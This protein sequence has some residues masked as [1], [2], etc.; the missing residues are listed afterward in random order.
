MSDATL[1]KVLDVADDALAEVV[2]LGF[3]GKEARL[4][5]RAEAGNVANAVRHAQRAREER[6]R[7]AEEERTKA[8]KRREY[9]RTA[10][11]EWVNQGCVSTLVRMGFPEMYAVAALRQTDNDINAAVDVIQNKPEL[12]IAAMVEINGSKRERGSSGYASDEDDTEHENPKK[13]KTEMSEEETRRRKE[14]EEAMDRLHEAI[15][16]V[17]ED[18][19]LDL[20]LGEDRELLK[21]YQGFLGAQ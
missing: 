13:E 11:G 8:K 4:A 12:L 5:L 7:V 2:A 17:G 6:R 9:G 19:H 3:T 14:A 20:A 10:S 21:K 1:L 18:D 15:G 16:D